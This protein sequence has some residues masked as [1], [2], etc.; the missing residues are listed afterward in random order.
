M[1]NEH[2]AVVERLVE[3]GA[4]INAKKNVRGHRR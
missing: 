3:M 4:D 1:E 2:A